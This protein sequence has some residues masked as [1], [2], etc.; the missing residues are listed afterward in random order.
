MT[1]PVGS[2][3]KWGHHSETLAQNCKCP[4]LPW[5]C[6]SHNSNT[7]PTLVSVTSARALPTLS[8]HRVLTVTLCWAFR[9]KFDPYLPSGSPQSH[10]AT[11]LQMKTGP[12]VTSEAP[13]GFLMAKL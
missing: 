5:V 11:V 9:D 13:G 6:R 1:A 4:S 7:W 12:R 2:S 8:F 10:G 3:I